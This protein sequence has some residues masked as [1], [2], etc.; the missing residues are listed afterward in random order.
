[1]ELLTQIQSDILESVVDNDNIKFSSIIN[2]C[3]VVDLFCGVGGLTH[4]FVKERF[5]VKAG[6]DNDESCCYAY[7]TNNNAKFIAKDI[8]NISSEEIKNL[9]SPNSIKILVGCAPCQ[10]FSSYNF[11]NEDTKKWFLLHEFARLIK[12]VQPDIVSMENVPQLLNFTKASVFQ[13]FLCSLTDNDYQVDYQIVDCP[14][15]GIPQKRKRLV[16]LASKLGKISLIAP[17]HNEANFVTVRDIIEKLEPLQ[18]G[19]QSKID[20]LHKASSLNHI[21][22]QRIQQSKQGG[23][24]RDWDETLRLKCHTKESGK[25]YVSVYGRM[26]WDEPAPTITTQCN[27]LGNGRFGHPEQDRAISLREAA[28]LQTFPPNYSFFNENKNVPTRT[29][30]THIGNAVPVDLGRVIA[31]SIKKHLENVQ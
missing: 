15:Y 9:Y 28:L 27:G 1:M 23:T 25:S 26:N 8:N 16:L 10:P 11:K 4:G 18:H 20:V 21:N 13:D 22:L 14:K 7:E 19:E 6:I 30:A 31:K 2:N 5:T 12:D 24:W 17:T 3:E 29:I